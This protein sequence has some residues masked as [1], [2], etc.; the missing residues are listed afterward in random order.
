MKAKGPDPH[1]VSQWASILSEPQYLM[2]LARF[3]SRSGREFSVGWT[4]G[5]YAMR[6]IS[7]TGTVSSLNCDRCR[8]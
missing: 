2:G 8:L 4:N 7:R 1:R 6:L 3:K 5:M